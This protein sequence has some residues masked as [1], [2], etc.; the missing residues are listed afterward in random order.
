MVAAATSS[1]PERAEAGRNYDYRYVWIRDQCYA[2]HAFA[3]IGDPRLL[4][5]AV[6][7]V[8]HRL[9]EDGD[10][11]APAYTAAGKPIPDQVQLQLPGYPGGFDRIGNWVNQQF[12]LDAF[13]EALLLFADAAGLDAMDA[14]TWRA[15]SIAADAIANRW[16]EPDAGIWEIA[17][18]NWTHSRLTAAAGLKALSRVSSSARDHGDW[19]A[20]SDR[21]VA[22]TAASA[23]H[24]DGY[25][26]RAPD[27]PGLDGSLLLAGIR[28]AVPAD[29][30][31]TVATLRAYERQLTSDHFAYRF[32]HGEGA[33]SDAEGSFTLCGF[34]MALAVHQQGDQ[35]QARGWWERTRASCGPPMLYSEEYDELEHQ[36]RG[37]LPQA[38]V[39][40]GMLEATAALS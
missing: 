31:R 4:H 38:F 34:L 28:G 18:Q 29:D 5:D 30:P 2:G 20:L 3:A 37:N 32:R 1:L 24:P 7:F 26:Q 11:M 10:R 13:G 14:D 25:W 23:T 21:I 33:L 36:M 40:A 35:I 8:T 19:M 15:A 39:H 27:D 16:T 22:E 9:L 6:R 12:Q 17:P